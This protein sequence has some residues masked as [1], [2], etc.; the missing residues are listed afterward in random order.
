MY[1]IF[2]LRLP[3]KKDKIHIV[4]QMAHA[5]NLGEPF[6]AHIENLYNILCRVKPVHKRRDKAQFGNYRPIALLPPLSK[7]FERV[8]LK[9]KKKRNRQA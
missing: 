1:V 5:K 2:A 6:M 4:S 9:K 8:M 7:I 3:L